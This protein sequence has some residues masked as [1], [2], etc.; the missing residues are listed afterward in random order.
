MAVRWNDVVRRARG[1]GRGSA[2]RPTPVRVRT[3]PRSTSASKL[4]LV[5]NGNASGV[6]RSDRFD[7]ARALLRSLGADVVAVLAESVEEFAASWA[8]A[9]GRRVVLLGG[10][11]TVHTAV[12]L[13]GRRPPIALLPAGGANNIARSLGVPID[14]RAAAKLAVEGRP[15]AV[16]LIRA[17]TAHE[18]LIVVEGVSAG[19][20]ALA[21]ARYAAPNSA[22]VSAAVRA[23]AGALARYHGIDVL[24]ETD[25]LSERLTLGQLFVANFPRYAFGLH[26]APTAR[27]DD[28]L[29]DVVALTAN[30]S[31]LVPVL[32]SLR[33]GTHV[34]R[35]G[36]RIWTAAR[37][38]LTVSGSP[39]I[40]DTTPLA[41]GPVEL[42]VEPRTLRVIAPR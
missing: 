29:L 11:G 9:D 21:R 37:V 16:D 33:H 18:R 2:V 32:V 24:V 3:R 41:P 27:P 38:R 1:T 34:G 35:P 22:D 30:R 5:G 15:R 13:P 31:S 28:G 26:V 19:L 17:E 20:H 39:V 6:R 14:L 7:A 25:S 42:T 4:L 8:A 23:G 36:V 40:A 10:D 12:N